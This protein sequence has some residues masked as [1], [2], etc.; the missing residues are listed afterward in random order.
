MVRR[1]YRY[2]CKCKEKVLYFTG[3][4][5]NNEITL[6]DNCH[7]PFVGRYYCKDCYAK[8]R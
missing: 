8:G 6:L 1:D 7:T 2:C 4:T 3:K 5:P